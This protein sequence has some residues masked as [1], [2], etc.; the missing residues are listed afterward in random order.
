MKI[1]THKFSVIKNGKTSQVE[2]EFYVGQRSVNWMKYLKIYL[3]KNPKAHS[4]PHD[5]YCEVAS[6][7]DTT[8]G[9]PFTS[10]NFKGGEVEHKDNLTAWIFHLVK[11]KVF[12]DDDD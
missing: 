2:A 9:Q 7:Y 10:K 3:A 8:G 11:E 12:D 4:T 6:W 1:K 5:L